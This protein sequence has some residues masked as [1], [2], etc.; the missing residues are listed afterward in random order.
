MNIL[1]VSSSELK[2]NV[3][4]ILNNVYFHRKTAVINRYG[5]TIAKIVPV[6]KA[7]TKTT[8]TK[9]LLDKYFGIL[10]DFPDVSKTR[11]FRKRNIKL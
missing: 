2:Q 8:N 1:N 11:T 4:E 6:A 7:D 5:K 10:P 3:A 9:S